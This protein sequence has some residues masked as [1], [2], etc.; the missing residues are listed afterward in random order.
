[1]PGRLWLLPVPLGADSDPQQ[2]LPAETLAVMRRLDCF[3]V[4]HAKTARAFL[5]AAGVSTPLQ[6]LEL[7]ELN[8]HTPA[9]RIPEL[10]A[11]LAAGRDVGLLSEAGCPAVA[12]PG[13]DLVAA[14][15][16]AGIAV[17]PMVGPSSILLALMASGLGGQRFSFSGYLPTVPA[18][19]LAA[20][21]ALEQRSARDDDTVL[22]IETPY[23]NQALIEAALQALAPGTRLLI[24][25][26]LTLPD[27]RIEMK[28]VAQWRRTPPSLPKV[29]TVFGLRAE[30]RGSAAR[31]PAAPAAAD[32]VPGPARRSGPRGRS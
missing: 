21:R 27:E 28:T 29:P 31:R 16:A 7:H 12:D 32:G 25:A 10:L 5:K 23:R 9:A 20:L 24:A 1:M 15:H 26:S 17:K 6:A 2:I 8:E 18:E 4:E 14:A 30:A 11:P 3:I 13:A 22:L 19:R